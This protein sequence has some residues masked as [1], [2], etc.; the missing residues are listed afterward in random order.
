MRLHTLRLRAFGPYAAEQ[1]IDFDRLAHGGLFLLEGPTGSGKTTILDAV[2]F[3]LYGG[4]AG[5]D[6]A[7]D[8]LRSHFVTADTRTEV[9]LEWSL[10]GVRY[11]VTRSPE[12]RR[13]KKRGEGLTTEA[14][15]VH[16]QRREGTA[17]ASLSASKAEAGEMIAEAVGLTRVQF[18]QVMLL[19]QG[20]FAKFLRSGDDDRRKLLTKLF[21]TGLYDRITSE[22][23]ARRTDATRAR[24]WARQAVSDAVSAAAEAA[25]L[26]A[27]ERA[28]LLAAS[29]AEQQTRLKELAENLAQTTAVTGDALEIATRAVITAQAEDEEAKRQDSLMT[30]LTRALAELTAHDG[31]RPEHEQRAALLAAAR[32]AE[33]VRPLLEALADATA[34]VRA[35]AGDL[36]ELVPEP[37]EDALA[38]RGGDDAA[39]RAE[40]ADIEAAALQHAVDG[41]QGLPVREAELAGL[42]RDVAAAEDR[43]AALERARKD[44]PDRIAALE[45]QLAEAHTTA[46]GLAVVSQQLAVIQKRSTA[47][48]RLA[49]LEPQLAALDAARQA[50]GE[51]HKRVVGEHQLLL[52]ARVAGIAAEL[53]AGLAEGHPCPVCGSPSHPEPAR[54]RANAVSAEEVEAARQRHEAADT[55][56]TQAEREYTDLAAEVAGYRAVADGD[57]VASLAA[58]QEALAGQVAQAEAAGQDGARLDAELAGAR[59][60]QENVAG[61]L[62]EAAEAAAAARTEASRAGGDLAGLRAELHDAARGHP[63]VAARQAALHE[64]AAQD[65]ALGKALDSLAQRIAVQTAARGRAEA[66]ARARGFGSAEEAAAA[67]L[68]SQEQADLATEV[69]SWD[70]TL[71]ALTAA[72][73]TPE[74]AGLDPARAQETAARA[75]TAAAALTRAREAEQ[76]VRDAHEAA[77]VKAGR[78]GQRHDEV[79]AAE[80]DY[81]RLTELTEPV[82]HLA[83]LANG[84]EGHRRVALTTYV[85]RYWFGQVVAAANVRLSAMSSG[86]YELRRTDEGKG[87]SDR[88]GLTLAVI[89]R[90]TGEE[91][92]PASLSGGETFYTSLALALGLADVV[93]AQAGGVDT[94]TLFIDEGF[95]SLDADT[96]DQVMGVIDDLRDRGRVI[97]IVSHVTD[98]KD[99]VPERLEVRRLADGSSAVKVV[100]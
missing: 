10:R 66:E 56:R 70:E 67:A 51:A 90:H 43:V 100:A 98:L 53:A 12:Y 63:S 96:L 36:H 99:R 2:T 81:D 95:G 33:P 45:T 42:E 60:E 13:P 34:T 40:A 37:D 28:Q 55:K 74:L 14:S 80:A 69:R 62:R 24:E 94:D 20:E 31:T 88:S 3:A 25:G 11:K 92:S 26:D 44:L 93:K 15:R 39:A 82:I 6:S 79:C 8:R 17:W 19:P 85:L 35:A 16:L 76:E 21:G 71:A 87:K 58:E 97:G 83:G 49:E 5:E 27:G 73:A 41:E 64:S 68:T 86:R 54:A 52:D 65:R 7:D 47:A 48:V 29:R 9:V 78:L 46:A 75:L 22:L 77:K 91:R 30:R 32:H 84:T 18:T 23:C 57:S 59:A 72:V 4:L 89:D 61:E 38:G 1:L 50:A